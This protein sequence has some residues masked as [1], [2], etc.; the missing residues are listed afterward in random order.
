MRYLFRLLPFYKSYRLFA[1]T[2][3]NTGYYEYLKFKLRINKTHF[4]SHKNCIIANSKGIKLGVNC[5]IG[6]PGVYI[7]GGGGV[8]FGNYVQL[9]PNVGI[10]SS[11]HDLYNQYKMNNAK[12]VIGD[13]SWIG[14]NSVVTAGVVLGTRT[15]VA[16]GSVVTKSFPEGFCVIGGTP[17]KLI[18]KLDK[19]KFNPWCD[20]VECIGFKPFKKE[21]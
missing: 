7:Q 4:P 21:S 14:M 13:Y 11:N 6:R 2:P 17:A 18:K 12:I 5:L 10:L 19:D 16:A 3:Q 8:S 15:V 9:G 1:K 20:E